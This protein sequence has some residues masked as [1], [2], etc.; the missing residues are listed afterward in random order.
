M[1]IAMIGHKRIPSREGG[2]EVVV[3]SLAVRMAK[4]GHDVTAYNRRGKH[5]ALGKR[6][7]IKEYEGVRIKN[8]PTFENGKLN[9]VVYSVLASAAALFGRYDVIHFHAEGP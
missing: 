9:A 4:S 8:I 5:V 2:V 1:K 3:E 7:D 6:I